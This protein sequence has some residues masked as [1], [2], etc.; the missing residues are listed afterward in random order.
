MKT[1]IEL[2]RDISEITDKINSNFP[3]LSMYILE[4]PENHSGNKQ[5]NLKN[6]EDYYQSLEVLVNQYA[7]TH[8]DSQTKIEQQQLA[9][10]TLPQYPPSEDIFNKSKNETDLNPED[11]SKR[12]APNLKDETRNEIGFKEDITGD[13]LD[14][15]GSELDDEQESKGSEDEENNYYSIGGDNHNDLEEVKG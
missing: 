6:L 2:E 13:D 5:V 7:D 12:K 8:K 4:M 14:I 15:P 9:H 3:E 1:K 10:S 11:L